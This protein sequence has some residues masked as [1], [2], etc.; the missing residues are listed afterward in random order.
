MSFANL[1]AFK[2][3]EI[4]LR[5]FIFQFL[6]DNGFQFINFGVQWQIKLI[7]HCLAFGALKPYYYLWN[8]Q[9]SF[10]GVKLFLIDLF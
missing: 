7:G 1:M 10:V 4:I 6:I 5:V 2:K 9:Y 3:E 8:I